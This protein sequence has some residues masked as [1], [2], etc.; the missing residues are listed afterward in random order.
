ML[1]AVLIIFKTKYLGDGVVWM[2][3]CGA[4]QYVQLGSYLLQ[5]VFM[6]LLVN[7]LAAALC[8]SILTPSMESKSYAT[9]LTVENVRYPEET[10]GIGLSSRE[11]WRKKGTEKVKFSS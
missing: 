5:L 4:V 11:T 1:I 7:P 9:D 8:F 10:I 6:F 3:C 2:M